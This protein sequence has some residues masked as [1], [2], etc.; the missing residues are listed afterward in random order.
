[1]KQRIAPLK[2][3]R[4]LFLQIPLINVR[5]GGRHHRPGGRQHRPRGR[6][7][8]PRGRYHRP[9]GRHHRPGALCCSFAPLCQLAAPRQFVQTNAG[10]H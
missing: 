5:A 1:M 6:Q 7:H 9:G 8:R 10:G 3:H 4:K 2:A